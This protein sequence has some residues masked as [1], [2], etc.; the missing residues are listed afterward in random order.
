MYVHIKYGGDL[1]KKKKKRSQSSEGLP[2]LVI[3][4]QF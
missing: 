2:L 1:K 3:F 4:T